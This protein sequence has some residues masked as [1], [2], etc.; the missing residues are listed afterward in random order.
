MCPNPENTADLDKFTI[1]ILSGKLY[2][3]SN[4]KVITFPGMDKIAGP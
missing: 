4:E 3:L 2:F 1:K